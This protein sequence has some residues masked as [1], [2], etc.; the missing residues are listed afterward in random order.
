MKLD[1]RLLVVDDHPDNIESA[2][3]ILRDSLETRGFTLIRQT[4][5]DFSEQGLQK[6]TQ[7]KGADFDLVVIDYNLGQPD[8]DGA[9]VADR[10]RRDLQYTDMVFYSSIPEANL[11][12][13]LAKKSVSGVFI[14]RRLDLDNALTGIANTVIRKVVDLNHMRGI[15]M[16]EVAE[17]DVRMQDTLAGAFRCI[18]NPCIDKAISR[19]GERLREFLSET[20]DTL[21]QYVSNGNFH[22]AVED[23][24]LFSSMQKYRALKRIAECLPEHFREAK[25]ILRNYGNDIIQKRNMLAHVKETNT[26]DGS[27]V[28]HSINNNHEE[29][30]NEAW[31][32]AFRQNLRVHGKALDVICD[33]LDSHFGDATSISNPEED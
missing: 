19:T 18:S 27:I 9:K 1:F 11:H 16:A 6:L 30:I 2:I 29:I 17:M 28:L 24:R 25:D 4:A 14:T 23:S 26:E 20:I 33:A 10:L 21:D 13:E 8:T 31:M 5:V 7:A 32:V 3:N 12:D 22:D 15:V